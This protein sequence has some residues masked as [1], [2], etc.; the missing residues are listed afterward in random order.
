MSHVD[1]KVSAP[2]LLGVAVGF[3]LLALGERDTGITVILTALGG[4]A[5]GYAKKS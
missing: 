3:G 4:G 5:V 1:P 2:T